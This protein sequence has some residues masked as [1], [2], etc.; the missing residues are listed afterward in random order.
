MKTL[1]VCA[2]ILVFAFA[3][4]GSLEVDVALAA[5]PP[6]SPRSIDS[7]HAADGDVRRSAPLL[8]EG[9]GEIGRAHV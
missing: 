6:E 3:I 8:S 5:Q 9:G 7:L 4:V 2:S 1:L